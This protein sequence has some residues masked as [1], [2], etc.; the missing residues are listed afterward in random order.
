M[1]IETES[2]SLRE[3]IDIYYEVHLSDTAF[4]VYVFSSV[5][6]NTCQ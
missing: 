6:L 3:K 1:E 4:L 2:L 5:I